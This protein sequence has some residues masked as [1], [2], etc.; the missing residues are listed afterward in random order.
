MDNRISRKS[1][2]VTD[3]DLENRPSMKGFNVINSGWNPMAQ[4]PNV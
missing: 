2:G 3:F 4:D 1:W